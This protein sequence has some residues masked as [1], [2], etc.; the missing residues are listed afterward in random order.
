MALEDVLDLRPCIVGA[1]IAGLTCAHA[2]AKNGFK[3]INVYKNASNRGFVGA[4]IQLAANSAR[5]LE[6]A[7]TRDIF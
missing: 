4:G 6:E 1:G 2:L 5:G 3:H 7:N